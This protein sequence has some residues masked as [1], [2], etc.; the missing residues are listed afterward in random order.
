MYLVIGIGLAGLALL[1]SSW[2]ILVFPAVF[3]LLMDRFYIPRQEQLLL[4]HFGQGYV[5]YQQRV[6]RWL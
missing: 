1:L 2:L 3:G 4:A 5:G 6:R